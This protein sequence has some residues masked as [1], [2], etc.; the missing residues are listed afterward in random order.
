[1]NESQANKTV[2]ITAAVLVAAALLE[3]KFNPVNFSL[4]KKLWGIGA[5]TLALAITADFVPE[6]AGPLA[7][8][9]LA[10][11]AVND[12]KYFGQAI[13]SG[14]EKKVVNA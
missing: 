10:A 9:I 4:Y 13:N 6:V 12:S 8:L 2:F 11:V 5:L 14:T 3:K 1:M 7:L